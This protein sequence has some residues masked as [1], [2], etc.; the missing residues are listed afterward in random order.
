MSDTDVSIVSLSDRPELEDQF[1]HRKREIWPEFMFHDRYADEYWHYLSDSFSQYQLYAVDA[2]GTPLAV[3]QSIPIPWNGSTDGLPTGWFECLVWGADVADG[4]AEPTALSALEISVVAEARGKGI[5]GRLLSALR[6]A[7]AANQLSD[8]V[9]AVRPSLKPVYPLTPM[10]QYVRW[11]RDDGAPF[12]PWLRVH[13]RAGGEILHVAHP[14]MV[15]DGTLEEWEAWTGMKFPASGEFVVKDAL[16][17]VEIDV[18]T[19]RGR[20]VEPNVWVRHHTTT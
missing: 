17:P 9:I 12:D 1:W 3:A 5:S 20:Y 16:V 18:E 2:D 4:V 11:K 14:S 8:L 19:R 10:V 6:S 13:W 7:A 15:V